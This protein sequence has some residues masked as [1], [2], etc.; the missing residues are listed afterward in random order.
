MQR[1]TEPAGWGLAERLGVGKEPPGETLWGA[2]WTSPIATAITCQHR[3]P[4][5]E[6]SIGRVLVSPGAHH[7]A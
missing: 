4:E 3:P 6:C 7:N 1:K 2:E 5:P